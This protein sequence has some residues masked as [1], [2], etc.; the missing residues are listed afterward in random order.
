MNLIH[1]PWFLCV[2]VL[3]ALGGLLCALEGSR[4]LDV[5]N[6]HC[7]VLESLQALD[8]WP[9]WSANNHSMLQGKMRA[10]EKDIVRRNCA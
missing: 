5:Y 8:T 2:Q 10:L 9:E 6:L 7:Q 3:V 4:L 1:H